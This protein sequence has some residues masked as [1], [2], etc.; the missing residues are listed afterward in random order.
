ME[1]EFDVVAKFVGLG[2]EGHDFDTFAGVAV[3]SSMQGCHYSV[4]ILYM[5]VISRSQAKVR[6]NHSKKLE[7]A[8]QYA[9]V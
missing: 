7:D 5:W 3:S 8:I 2:H 6:I 9:R 4:W 1:D